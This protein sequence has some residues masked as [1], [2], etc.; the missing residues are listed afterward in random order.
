M[1]PKASTATSSSA[2]PKA[3]AKKATNP[4]QKTA[5]GS[6]AD[7]CSRRQLLNM[8]FSGLDVDVSGAV[9]APELMALVQAVRRFGGLTEELVERVNG[10]FFEKMDVEGLGAVSR[11]EFI[12]AYSVAMHPEKGKFQKEANNLREAAWQVGNGIGA[13]TAS[14]QEVKRNK[15]RRA[16]AVVFD[17]LDADVSGTLEQDELNKFGQAMKKVGEQEGNWTDS[18]NKRLF[19]SLDDSADGKVGRDEFITFYD[20]KLPRDEDAFARRLRDLEEACGF[21][22]PSLG[23]EAKVNATMTL[24]WQDRVASGST[25]VVHW[26]YDKPDGFVQAEPLPSSDGFYRQLLGRVAVAD[27][28][29]GQRHQPASP[30]THAVTGGQPY[31]AFT[32]MQNSTQQLCKTAFFCPC[33]GDI[34]NVFTQDV[35]DASGK[36]KERYFAVPVEGIAKGMRVMG[37]PGPPKLAAGTA[38]PLAQPKQ[39]SSAPSKSASPAKAKASPAKAKAKAPSSKSLA[40]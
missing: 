18:M 21:A 28:R 32:E 8:V 40:K 23:S 19:E 39:A 11:E 1:A 38:P 5:T 24:K 17:E 7:E 36:N 13:G 33:C 14:V 34:F 4:A 9:E 37:V 26:K 31:D 25:N 29:V 10:R 20:S 22:L 12:Q 35:E 16:L 15:R 27:S 2:S 30:F 3:V 6:P